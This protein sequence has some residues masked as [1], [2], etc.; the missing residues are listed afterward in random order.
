MMPQDVHQSHI[1]GVGMPVASPTVPAAF[2]GISYFTAF[3]DP[4]MFSV[5]KTQSS[6][7]R[8]RRKS[9]S[10]GLDTVKHRRTRSGCFMCRS[11]RVKVCPSRRSCLWEGLQLI[12]GGSATK[13]DRFASVRHG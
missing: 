3:H 7:Q 10:G 2:S 11:R 13:R 4:M 8:S 6:S 5:P 12:L 1:P 9:T